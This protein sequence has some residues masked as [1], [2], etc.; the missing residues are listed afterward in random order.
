MDDEN[1]IDYA[2]LPHSELMNLTQE[3]DSMREELLELQNQINNLMQKKMEK[4]F[5]ES[6]SFSQENESSSTKDLIKPTVETEE[7][8]EVKDY[9]NESK[10]QAEVV[11]EQKNSNDLLMTTT[12][13]KINRFVLAQ[14]LREKLNDI[15]AA[16]PANIDALVQGAVN[17][18]KKVI[19]NEADFYK[20]LL[21]NNLQSFVTNKH[22]FQRYIR[23]SFFKI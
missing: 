9:K 12:P 1:L 18:S 10:K 19:D 17:A 14:Q 6:G 15:D 21:A 11:K 23:P 16:L 4:N 2:F 8:A 5:E 3:K 22:K 7:L 20:L 13:K